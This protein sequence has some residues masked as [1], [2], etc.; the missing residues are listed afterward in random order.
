MAGLSAT[1]IK[2]FQDLIL[3]Y[4][5]IHLD[6]TKCNSLSPV[7]SQYLSKKKFNR[8]EKYSPKI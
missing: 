7:I 5:G 2:L 3:N 8:F 6:E 4:S 1:E